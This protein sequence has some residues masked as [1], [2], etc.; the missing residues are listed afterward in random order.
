MQTETN[1]SH[2]MTNEYNYTEEKEGWKKKKS[3]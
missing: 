3:C 1:E 2:C